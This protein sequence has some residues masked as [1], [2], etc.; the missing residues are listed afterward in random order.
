MLLLLLLVLLV[1]L[2]LRRLAAG[3]RSAG[4]GRSIRVPW[5]PLAPVFA[6]GPPEEVGLV[7]LLSALGARF[8]GGPIVLTFL[9]RVAPRLLLAAARALPGIPARWVPRDGLE[10]AIGHAQLRSCGRPGGDLHNAEFTKMQS[11]L[12]SPE[13]GAPS[14]RIY[15]FLD[16][17]GHA[18]QHSPRHPRQG[19]PVMGPA[20]GQ[21]TILQKGTNQEL[22]EISTYTHRGPREE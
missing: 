10:A 2:L 17:A 6:V 15:H 9:R 13:G 8:F 11:P 7:G 22:T 21:R 20:T 14:E 19:A 3:G 5:F 1:P 4:G 18:P 12:S 16:E